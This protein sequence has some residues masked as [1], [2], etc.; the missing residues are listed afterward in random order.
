MHHSEEL[1]DAGVQ[2]NSLKNTCSLIIVG[3]HSHA[4]AWERDIRLRKMHHGEER[5]DA[6]GAIE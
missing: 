5:C 4:G 6:G 2:S 3:L 1:R